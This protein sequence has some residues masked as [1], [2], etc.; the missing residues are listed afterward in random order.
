MTQDWHPSDHSSFASSHEGKNPFDPHEEEGIGPVLWPDHC[1]QGS[2]GAEFHPDLDLTKAKAIIRK[3]YNIKID[4]YS[5][6]MENDRKTLTGLSGY[7]K[8]INILRI[9][10]C[11]LALDYCVYFTAI[12]GKNLGFDVFVIPD[13]SRGIDD[14][15]N[16]IKNTLENMKKNGIKFVKPQDIN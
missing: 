15:K 8:S 7:L 9:F 2:K 16:N 13:L 1:V 12:D 6:F 4:S 10:L 5:G 3:G 14:P 11:G